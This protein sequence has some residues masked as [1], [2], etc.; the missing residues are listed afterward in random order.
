MK[1]TKI[2][3]YKQYYH[4]FRIIICFVIQVYANLYIL[5][6]I[7]NNAHMHVSLPKILIHNQEN[8][9]KIIISRIQTISVHQTHS[10][11]SIL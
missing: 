4:I 3:Y 8:M 2:R 9:K 1:L 10:T 5:F 7:Q 11:I 6:I